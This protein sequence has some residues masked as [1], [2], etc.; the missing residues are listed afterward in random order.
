M[1][2]F[3]SELSMAF[4]EFAKKLYLSCVSKLIQPIR[5]ACTNHVT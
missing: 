4:F 2:V 1:S 3:Y 5:C